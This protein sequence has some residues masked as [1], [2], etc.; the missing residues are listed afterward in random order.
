MM[1]TSPSRIRMMSGSPP[2]QTP[3]FRTLGL[4]RRSA[5]KVRKSQTPCRRPGVQLNRRV[6]LYL[7]LSVP[8]A[9]AENHAVRGLESGLDSSPAKPRSALR[10]G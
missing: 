4:D 5:P 1:R 7:P 8:M 10:P 3:I 2:G 9:A 6:P